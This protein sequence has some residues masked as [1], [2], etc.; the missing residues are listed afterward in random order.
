MEVLYRI[1]CGLDVHK[2]TVV[3]CLSRVTGAGERVKQVRTFGTTR[4]GLQR[5]AA[6]LTEAGCT[7]LAMESTGV[8]WKNHEGRALA[9]TG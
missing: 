5:L 8:Y 2:D 3:A 6:W 1:C 9:D 7:H 4:T